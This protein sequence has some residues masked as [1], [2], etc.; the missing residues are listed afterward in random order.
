MANEAQWLSTPVHFV[1][2]IVEA[3]Y[4]EETT[5]NR[6]F[7]RYAGAMLSRCAEDHDNFLVIFVQQSLLFERRT[8]GKYIYIANISREDA[9]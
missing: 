3:H 7:F 1:G 4:D 9:N 6:E 5:P 8:T 2:V